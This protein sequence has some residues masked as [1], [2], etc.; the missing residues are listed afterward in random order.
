MVHCLPPTPQKKKEKEK[1]EFL[2]PLMLLFFLSLHKRCESRVLKVHQCMSIKKKHRRDFLAS[3]FFGN[4][5]CTLLNHQN[6]YSSFENL[7]YYWNFLDYYLYA[8]CTIE[9]DPLHQYNYLL[10]NK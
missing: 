5:T 3:K 9:V 1:K 8:C 6:I 2:I 4:L 7:S 10:I